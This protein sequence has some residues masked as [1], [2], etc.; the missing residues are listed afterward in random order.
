M[1]RRIERVN[2]LLAEE[3]SELIRREIQDPRLSA[4][5]SV[6]EVHTSPDLRNA[7]VLVSV[8][9]TEEEARQALLAL[10]HAAGYLRHEMAE[11][12]RIKH[13]PELSFKQDT[14]IEKG[15]RVLQILK[16]IQEE[17]DG[18]PE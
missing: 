14:S 2:A 12:L 15:A 7:T 3:I 11:R 1:T 8:L 17:K 16:E 5:V 9:G 4:M 10:R 6:T 13:I 18:Q